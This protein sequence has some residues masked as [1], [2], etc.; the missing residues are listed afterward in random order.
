[1]DNRRGNSFIVQA[2]CLRNKAGTNKFPYAG[3]YSTYYIVH[4]LVSVIIIAI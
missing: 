2:E 3:K 1:M 4:I